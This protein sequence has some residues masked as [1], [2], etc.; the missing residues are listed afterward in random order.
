MIQTSMRH[1]LLSRMHSSNFRVTTALTTLAW[2]T[3]FSFAAAQPVDLSLQQAHEIALKKNPN[4]IVADLQVL[5]AKQH[6]RQSHAAFY[7]IIHGN[8]TA[9]GTPEDRNNTLAAGYL[10][11]SSIYSRQAEGIDVN[12]LVFM[13]SK[14]HS[15]TLIRSRTEK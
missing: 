11:T 1:L 5:V 12:Q 2:L 6:V 8:V 13:R 4:I 10:T 3:F 14:L 15:R 7:P 9:V